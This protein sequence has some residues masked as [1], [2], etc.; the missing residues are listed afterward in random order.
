MIRLSLTR[1]GA[2]RVEHAYESEGRVDDFALWAQTPAGST[3][4]IRSVWND[5]RVL[6]AI[7]LERERIEAEDWAEAPSQQVS[8]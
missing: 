5:L 7:W 4:R 2:V 1:S 6:M 3:R 8:S